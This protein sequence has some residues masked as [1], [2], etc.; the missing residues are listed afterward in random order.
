M[1]KKGL[2][3][4]TPYSSQEFKKFNGLYIRGSVDNCPL[5]HFTD[6]LN[7]KY[8]QAGVQSREGSSSYS[9]SGQ[10]GPVV[11][12]AVYKPNP[13]YSAG[14]G[15]GPRL[16]YMYQGLSAGFYQLIDEANASSPLWSWNPAFPVN[17]FSLA[18]FFGRA[19]ISLINKNVGAGVNLKVYDGSGPLG[20]RDAGGAAPSSTPTGVLSA[21]GNLQGGYFSI[22]VAFETKSGFITNICTPLV[23][24]NIFPNGQI[25]L[26]SIPIGGASIVARWIIC[27]QSIPV[28]VYT[29]APNPTGYPFFFV[30]RIGDNTTTTYN[31]SIFDTQLI[32]SA[33]YLLDQLAAIPAGNAIFPYNG[34]LI[35]V[36]QASNPALIWASKPGQP[37][38]FSASSGFATVDPTEVAGLRSGTE[39]RST[40]YVFASHRTYLT[41]DNGD[42]ISTWTINDF[43]KSIGTEGYGIGAVLDA[44]G[45]EITNF[46]V[47]D[48][49][50]VYLFDGVFEQPALTYKIKDLWATINQTYFYVS[51]I[52]VDPILQR[53]YIT[54][55]VGAS[56]TPNL[57]LVGDYREGLTPATIKWSKWQIS[58]NYVAQSLAIYNDYQATGVPI[59]QTRIAANN[60][61]N[62]YG[63]FTLD[64]SLLNDDGATIQSF[65]ELPPVR[66]CQGLSQYNELIVRATGKVTLAFTAYGQDKVI[67]VNPANLVLASDIPGR[68]YKQLMNLVSEECR[69]KVSLTNLNDY[70]LL[71][72]LVILGAAVAAERPR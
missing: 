22:G 38:S 1:A 13:P 40:L 59:I 36:G 43:S 31:L 69:L 2:P 14:L 5:D 28:S 55:P 46:L 24:N 4:L 20:I 49:S 30:H 68:E 66:F 25:A 33:D 35:L 44:K 72:R 62:T 17:D 63:V 41:Q 37:E 70:Y 12:M 29:A 15:N 34:R 6:C 3:T 50:G 54:V 61:L 60:G 39:Y 21:G 26:S 64:N 58:S 47:A 23:I 9:L 52:N 19:Y 7:T 10:A 45:A 53:I 42:E 32:N 67:S 27:T 51:Q 56:T 11:R 18:N 48:V 65:F 16:I 8:T 71:D 57:L